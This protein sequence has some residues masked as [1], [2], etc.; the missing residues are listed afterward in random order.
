MALTVSV[1]EFIG[2]RV[3]RVICRD[4]SEYNDVLEWSSRLEGIERDV[5]VLWVLV[6]PNE[7]KIYS[8]DVSGYDRVFME[9]SL[10]LELAEQS[11]NSCME[12]EEKYFRAMGDMLS[13]CVEHTSLVVDPDV[14]DVLEFIQSHRD[15]ELCNSEE[16]FY[17]VT[18]W[19]YGLGGRARDILVA[20][21]F[22]GCYDETI[23]PDVEYVGYSKQFKDDEMVQRI[24]ELLSRRYVLYTYSTDTMNKRLCADMKLIRDCYV[25]EY[26]D[27]TTC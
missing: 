17:R 15:K 2:S 27:S 20:W 22:C 9:S 8:D 23:C 21:I 19:F 13:C 12:D 5:F 4:A 3:G 18:D 16:S 25:N 10:F 24:G 1:Q 11:K 7:Q 26:S 14:S 6:G